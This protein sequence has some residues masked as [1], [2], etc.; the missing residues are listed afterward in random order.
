MDAKVNLQLKGVEAIAAVVGTAQ[1][2]LVLAGGP[3]TLV[4]I[5]PKNGVLVAD[6]PIATE[7][8]MAEHDL[9][10]RALAVWTDPKH[11]THAMLLQPGQPDR[12]LE[13]G[14]EP[15]ALDHMCLTH[16]RGWLHAGAELIGFGAGPPLRHTIEAELIGCGADAALA[17]IPTGYVI[18]GAECR[19]VASHDPSRIAVPAVVDGKLVEISVHGGV[20]QISRETGKAAYYSLPEGLELVATHARGPMALTDGKVIDVLAST[21]KGYAIVRL[22]AR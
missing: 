21:P 6:P 20:L 1:D 18:C 22:P 9:D 12:V 17:A 19:P 16:D 2:G 15:E 11:K 13:V 3:A 8:A 10:G 7:R 14:A 4:M 5:R